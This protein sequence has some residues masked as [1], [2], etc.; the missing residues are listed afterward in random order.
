M[1]HRTDIEI[2]MVDALKGNNIEATQS[3]NSLGVREPKTVR[4]LS[5]MKTEQLQ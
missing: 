1:R 3:V 5:E 4:N 2:L